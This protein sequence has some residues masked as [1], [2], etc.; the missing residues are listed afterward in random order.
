LL[1]LDE[2]LE[3]EYWRSGKV[4]SVALTSFPTK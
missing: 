2:M 4:N 3:P 1:R